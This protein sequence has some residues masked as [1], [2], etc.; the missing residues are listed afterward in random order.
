M[1]GPSVIQ[2]AIIYNEP[3]YGCYIIWKNLGKQIVDAASRLQPTCKISISEK[4]RI[5]EFRVCFGV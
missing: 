5:G 1:L 4:Q 2:I 3:Y